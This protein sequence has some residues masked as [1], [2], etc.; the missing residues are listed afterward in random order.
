MG[1]YGNEVRLSMA[2]E[3]YGYSTNMDYGMEDFSG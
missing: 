2:E 1:D 3:G